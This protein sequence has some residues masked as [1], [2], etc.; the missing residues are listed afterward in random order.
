MF[1][2]RKISTNSRDEQEVNIQG[3]LPG[4]TYRIRVVGNT[5]HQQGRT[6]DVLDITTQSEEGVVGTPENLHVAAIS[7]QAIYLKWDAP[8]VT[9]GP[10]LKYRIIYTEGENGAELNTE[11]STTEATLV[12]LRSYCEYT[13]SVAAINQNGMGIPTDEKLVKTFS[14]TPSEPPLNVSLEATSTTVN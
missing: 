9:N 5:N 14:N 7:D 1:R 13:V 3:L 11:V 12:D 4:K 10:L 8:K 2:E 6:S